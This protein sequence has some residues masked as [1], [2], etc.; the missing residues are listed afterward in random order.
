MKAL[1]HELQ[2]PNPDAS[3][4]IHLKIS[5]E[6][7]IRF[8]PDSAVGFNQLYYTDG[9]ERPPVLEP[10]S[11]MEPQFLNTLRMQSFAEAAKEQS[12]KTMPIVRIVP[13]ISRFA[14]MNTH[15]KPD[16]DTLVSGGNIWWQ[17]VA[18]LKSCEGFSC[19]YTLQPYPRSLLEA[20][21]KRGGNSLGMTPHAG[22]IVSIALLAY[23]AKRDD[24]ERIISTLNATLERL[25]EN[26]IARG[27]A[28]KF[29]CLNHSFDF[30]D[31]IRS[32]GVDNKI[33]LQNA[34]IQYDPDG[35]FQ[36]GVPG[37]W[38]LW[39]LRRLLLKA[40]WAF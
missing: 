5:L 17:S 37:G 26:A 23:W 25:D 8:M 10:F 6:T 30:Q 35:V 9:V 14:C 13:T 20:S 7:S 29:K 4:H 2:N 3:H 19:T 12:S 31:L 16:F 18:P 33:R 11:N 28:V 1:V 15:V 38:K 40:V 39:T 34:S 36:K 22:A 27:T 24:D 21:V 32:Y